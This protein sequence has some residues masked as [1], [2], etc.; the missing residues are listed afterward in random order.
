M[1]NISIH[2]CYNNDVYTFEF[3]S[4]AYIFHTGIYNEMDKKYGIDGL[5]KYV[6][7]VHECY[8]KDC[9][10]TPLGEFCDYVAQ[11]W[12]K[13]KNKTRYAILEEFYS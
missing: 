11:H 4:E 10:R 13:L 3:G 7:L 8:L 9:N 12:K 1:G 2:V 6:R 5:L